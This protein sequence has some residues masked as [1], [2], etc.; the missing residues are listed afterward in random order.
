MYRPVVLS[1]FSQ[2][3]DSEQNYLQFLEDEYESIAEAWEQYQIQAGSD[4]YFAVDFPARGSADGDKVAEDIRN[5][6]NRIVLFHFSG[7]AMSR[8]LLFKDGASNARGI[9]GLLGEAQNLKLVVLNG[10]AT[11]DQVKLLFDNNVKIVI[12]TKG[13]VSDG[14]AME[15]AATFYRAL[16]TR[17]YTIRGAFE[18][19]MN[20]LKRQ[21]AELDTVST[22]PIVWRGLVTE[23]EE[24]RDR[25][26][27]HIKS[28]KYEQELD[29]RDWWQISFV[30]PT[31]KDVALGHSSLDKVMSVLIVVLLALG[32]AIIVYSVF[33][34][35]DFMLAFIGL[36]ATALAYF[37][38]KNQQRYKT[39]ELNPELIDAA[40]IRKAS[41]FS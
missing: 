5:Y 34:K 7:H 25:W 21:H 37:F 20:E 19:A 12:A 27:L 38:V 8:H 13:K 24:D 17:D 28:S 35:E 1:Y 16:S 10:C 3:D 11:Y 6:K 18:H 29:R 32:V 41:M 23:T 40:M 22:Q 4:R 36:T 9:A 14:I 15:F 2:S 39:L 31:R 26:E 30:T 33:F